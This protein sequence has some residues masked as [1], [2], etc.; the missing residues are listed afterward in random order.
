MLLTIAPF[1][2]HRL[3]TSPAVADRPPDPCEDLSCLTTLGLIYR[4]SGKLHCS[5]LLHYV[6]VARSLFK[7]QGICI[8]VGLTWMRTTTPDERVFWI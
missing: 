1:V 2:S 8:P 3:A 7:V 6:C 4:Q 5:L